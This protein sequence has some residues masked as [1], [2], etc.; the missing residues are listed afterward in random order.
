MG[1]DI[2]MQ[3]VSI[4]AAATIVIETAIMTLIIVA[5]EIAIVPLIVLARAILRATITRI[6]MVVESVEID[7]I[8]VEVCGCSSGGRQQLLSLLL[9]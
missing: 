9:P 8:V 6:T 5:T 1:I 4:V 2:L 7:V 3:V